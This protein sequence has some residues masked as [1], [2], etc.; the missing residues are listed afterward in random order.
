MSDYQIVIDSAAVDVTIGTTAE[1]KTEQAVQYIKAGETEIDTYVE[2]TT[3]PEIDAYVENTSKPEIDA[4]VKS[5]TKPE[6]N[7]YVQNTS[8][9]DIAAYV[10][11]TTKP[12]IRDYVAGRVAEY[13]ANAAEKLSEYNSNDTS[14]TD[15]YN[16]NAADKQAEVDASATAAA[17][18]EKNA[19]AAMTAAKASAQAAA[20]SETEALNSETA[21]AESEARCEEIFARLGTVIK[22]KGRVDTTEDLP[23]S[24]NLDGDAYLVG[25]AGLTAYPEYYWFSDH[26]EFLGTSADKIEW[27]TLQGSIANQTDLQTALNNKQNVITGAASTITSSNLT[28]NMALKTDGNGKVTNSSTTSTELS[29]LSGVTSKIQTQI[30]GKQAT[31]T[32]G[33]TTIISSNLTANRALVSDGSGKVA[34]SAV[35]STQLGY[36]SSVTSDIQTQLNNKQTTA[37]LSQ[38]LDTSTIK[39][40]SNN[41]V[42]E[43]IKTVYPVGSLYFST[44]STCPLQSLGIGTWTKVGTSLTLSVN[45][46]AVVTTGDNYLGFNFTNSAGVSKDALLAT[47]RFASDNSQIGLKGVGITGSAYNA[48]STASIKVNSNSN[49]SATVTRTQLTVN[50]FQRTA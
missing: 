12:D 15:A 44:A 5:T 33:A 29:Y 48:G 26:W 11:N 43:Y 3:K 19:N 22:I 35:N 47:A 23:Q 17:Q 28:A 8:K 6:I 38:S 40:P 18:S 30:D 45:T 49:L 1:L 7:A 36:L 37:N 34:V 14:K 46:N 32:G 2:N 42:K 16:S 4:Y 10:E 21:A 27:G 41:A 24:G 9:P 25:Y 31:I 13:D 50:V 20:I 39:Y